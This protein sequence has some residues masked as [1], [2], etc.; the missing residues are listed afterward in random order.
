MGECEICGKSVNST[1][2]AEI[3][4]VILEVCDE[5]AKL[6]KEV[7]EPKPVLIK[8]TVVKESKLKEID[9]EEK[10]LVEDFSVKIKKA[11][12]N[13]KLTQDEA[14]DKI[15]ISRQIYKRIEGGFKA[16]EEAIRKIEKFFKINLYK[17]L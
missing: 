12:E 8:Q 6:G 14:A 1:K 15:G 17:K 10:E 9:E 4:G 3:D 2:K 5:C 11:R 7:S 16:D 13:L